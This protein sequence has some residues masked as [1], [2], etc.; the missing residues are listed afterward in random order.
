MKDA[1]IPSPDVAALEGLPVNEI[2][3][4]VGVA[5][6]SFGR[7]TVV[8]AWHI[9][10]ALRIVKDGRGHHFSTYCEGIGMSRSW[11]YDLLTLADGPLEKVSAERT[12]KGAVRL[13][14]AAPP[15]RQ[16][17]PQPES[18]A[19][20]PAEPEPPAREPDEITKAEGEA[21]MDEA[22]AETEADPVQIREDRLERLAIRT[23]D[24]DGDVV[25]GWAHKQDAAD[26]RHRDDVSAVNEAR[27]TAASDRRELR[28]V[29]DALLVVPRGDGRRGHR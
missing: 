28:D 11:A 22:A 19:D 26:V 24:I 20:A 10:R 4:A 13:L 27:K 21:A 25:E 6:Q 9:G 23:E 2:D 3:E 14:K 1:L 16:S 29:R 18:A 17:A 8:D 5:W 7:R 15:Q 12:V